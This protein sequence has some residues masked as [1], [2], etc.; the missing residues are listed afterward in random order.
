MEAAARQ[1]ALHL[2]DRA[3]DRQAEALGYRNGR[4]APAE[5]LK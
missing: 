4:L 3:R 5:L 1:R 2:G